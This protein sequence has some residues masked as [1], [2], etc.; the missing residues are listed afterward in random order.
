[1]ALSLFKNRAVKAAMRQAKDEY[2]KAATFDN[3]S[4]EARTYKIRI[5]IRCRANL[6]KVFIDGAKKTEIFQKKCMTA[7]ARGIDKPTPPAANPFQTVKT[8]S[9]QI[10]TYVPEEFAESVF[11]LGAMYQTMQIDAYKA[12]TL[13]QEV[14]DR[15]SFDLGLEEPI[16][17]LQFLRDEMSAGEEIEDNETDSIT[18]EDKTQEDN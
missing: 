2:I 4:R 15:M 9:G 16:I 8:I 10:Y 14:A 18:D 5:G 12:I 17:A 7:V 6:D 11:S 13:A 1:M 3:E